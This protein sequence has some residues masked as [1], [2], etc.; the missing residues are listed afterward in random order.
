MV[1]IRLKGYVI[2]FGDGPEPMY[3]HR[4]AKIMLMNMLSQAKDYVYMMSP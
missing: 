3:M 2:P 1:I 4:V